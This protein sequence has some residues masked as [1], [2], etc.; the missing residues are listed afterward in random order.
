MV[1]DE[2]ALERFEDVQANLAQYSATFSLPIVAHALHPSVFGPSHV[3][4][5]APIHV[6]DSP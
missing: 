4:H 3:N 6:E 1:I 2:I 5:P